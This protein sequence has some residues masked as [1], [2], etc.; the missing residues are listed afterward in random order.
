MGSPITGSR[1]AARQLHLFLLSANV[2]GAFIYVVLLPEEGFNALDSRLR[3]IGA[4]ITSAIA[5]LGLNKAL[6]KW[7]GDIVEAFDQLWAR[8]LVIFATVV[9]WSAV[10]PVWSHYMVFR[11]P[12]APH[13]TVMIEGKPREPIATARRTY[14]D[15]PIH[16]IEGLNLRAYDVEIDGRSVHLPAI[17]LLKGLVLQRSL[18][19]YLPCDVRFTDASFTANLE[20]DLANALK[21]DLGTASHVYLKQ[22]GRDPERV[23]LTEDKVAFLLPGRYEAIGFVQDESDDPVTTRSL[24]VEC[25]GGSEETDS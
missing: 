5:Y 10:L 9:V 22:L 1:M 13:P 4:L 12:D 3:S 19:I 21:D 25:E 23:P 15:L 18:D 16:V 17:S 2:V 8:V 24:V 14:D 20:E 11:P 7:A 6:Q